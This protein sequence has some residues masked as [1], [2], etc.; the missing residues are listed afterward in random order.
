MPNTMTADSGLGQLLP[1]EPVSVVQEGGPK[2][3][4]GFL[5]VGTQANGT[6]LATSDMGEQPLSHP[7]GLLQVV[8][9]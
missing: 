4:Q 9:A 2:H 7:K 5:P 3:P 8:E 1:G 6:L